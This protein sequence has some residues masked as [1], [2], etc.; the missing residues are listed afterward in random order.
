M[1]GAQLGVFVVRQEW[2]HFEVGVVSVQCSL[3][4]RACRFLCVENLSIS[5]AA[6]H[7]DGCVGLQFQI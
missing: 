5:R 7:S 3:N 4:N 6:I 1:L 2:D